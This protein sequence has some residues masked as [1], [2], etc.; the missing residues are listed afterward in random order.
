MPSLLKII[1]GSRKQVFLF[2][3]KR[4]WAHRNIY[5]IRKFRMAKFAASEPNIII[6][7]FNTD[8]VRWYSPSG[9]FLFFENT[10]DFKLKRCYCFMGRYCTP[11]PRPNNILFLL[12]NALQK[13]EQVLPD[14]DC[15]LP[16]TQLKEKHGW[17]ITNTLPPVSYFWHICFFHSMAVGLVA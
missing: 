6:L 4:G 11:E 14:T 10:S 5:N 12:C 8:S 2:Q 15:A 17:M 9:I 16:Y 7:C 3:W 1:F 13:K